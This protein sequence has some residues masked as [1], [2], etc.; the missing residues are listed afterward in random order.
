M[1]KV[2]RRKW[3]STL[4]IFPS[5][6]PK[7]QLLPKKFNVTKTGCTVRKC[8]QKALKS[9]LLLETPPEAQ[10]LSELNAISNWFL[11][12]AASVNLC[13]TNAS[14]YA[15]LLSTSQAKYFKQFSMP[16]INEAEISLVNPASVAVNKMPQE[17]SSDW[18]IVMDIMMRGTCKRKIEILFL[19][20]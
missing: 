15:N 7:I 18:P 19:R 11:P 1:T 4:A 10:G 3:S 12:G 14:L 13:S 6:Q 9:F 17:A 2:V 5:I 16:P 8:T 20:F